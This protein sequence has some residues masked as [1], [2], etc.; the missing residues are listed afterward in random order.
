MA[1]KQRQLDI[2]FGGSPAKQALAELIRDLPRLMLENKKLDTQKS[3]F[4]QELLQIEKE[5]FYDSNI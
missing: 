5:I 1:I 3:Q 2:A 4:Q